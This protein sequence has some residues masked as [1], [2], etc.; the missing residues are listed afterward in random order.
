MLRLLET[1]I[2]AVLPPTMTVEEAA[3]FLGIGRSTA[4][5]EA[6]RYRRTGGEV[7][8]PSLTIGGRVVVMT[9]PLL[10]MLRSRD[11]FQLGSDDPAGAVALD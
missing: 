5:T 6:A 3:R 7:G 9:V 11:A 1:T 8:L 10:D 4:Y 2:G